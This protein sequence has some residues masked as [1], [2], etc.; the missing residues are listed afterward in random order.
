MRIHLLIREALKL[1]RSSIPSNIEIKQKVA[2]DCGSAMADPTQVH[3]ILMNLCT[4][5]YHAMREEG[6]VLTVL[7]DVIEIGPGHYSEEFTDKD[8]KYLQLT[9]RD[10]GC[11]MDKETRE[12]IFEP[13]FTTKG[14]GEGT[15]L[16]MAVVHGI[17]RSHNGHISVK[18]EPGQG[19]EFHVFLPQVEDA[20]EEPATAEQRTPVYLGHGTIMVVDDEE[21]IVRLMHQML[22]KL[23]YEVVPCI[24]SLAAL[25]K[26]KEQKDNIDLLLTDMAMPGMTGIEL[27]REVRL[28]KPDLPVILCT[29]FS[30]KID[31]EKAKALGVDHF[32]LKPI[33][34]SKLARL[35]EETLA[36]QDA[37]SN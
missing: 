10:T 36:K 30:E 21:V 31:D 15:G 18:S 7:L 2:K 14:Q 27:L 32:M 26:F 5:A 23:G 22:V 17:V 1:L 16:G 4:N 8:G 12:R 13:Y 29:G 19:T 25:D 28:I 6:G 37:V 3:Q 33:L 35:L 20:E 9:V 24:S 34:M 11:G